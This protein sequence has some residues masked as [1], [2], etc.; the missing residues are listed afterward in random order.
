MSPSTTPLGDGRQD[1][2]VSSGAYLLAPFTHVLEETRDEPLR[3]VVDH[4]RGHVLEVEPLP[5]L[6]DRVT[7][8][9]DRIE[10]RLHAAASLFDEEVFEVPDALDPDS[11]E[12]RLAE[13]TCDIHRLLSLAE[14]GARQVPLARVGRL[15]HRALAQ[16][17]LHPPVLHA[18][19]STLESR[20]TAREIGHS[21]EELRA[22]GLRRVDLVH[23]TGHQSFVLSAC[24]V[25]PM[26]HCV[27]GLLQIHCTTLLNTSDPPRI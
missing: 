7:F 18:C 20:R 16:I 13:P 25:D 9:L 19:E 27:Y 15:G 1:P 17:D 4:G 5:A 24:R 26:Q 3:M 21:V 6:P 8:D 11:L 10:L 22:E 23:E 2:A 14:E 12:L